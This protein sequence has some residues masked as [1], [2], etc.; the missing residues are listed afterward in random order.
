MATKQPLK[1]TPITTT[2]GGNN[3][4]TMYIIFGIIVI[5]LIFLITWFAYLLWQPQDDSDVSQTNNAVSNSL[6]N[7]STKNKNANKNTNVEITDDTSTTNTNGEDSNSNEGLVEPDDSDNGSDNDNG[8]DNTNTEDENTET[9]YFAAST[10]SCG[11]TIA[12]E[13]ELEL[14]DDPYGEILLS[15]M[16]GPEVDDEGIDGIP[17]TVRLRQVEYTAAGP[18]ITVGEG[19]DTLTNC[20]KQ[21]VDAQF[22]KTANAMFDLPEDTAGEVVVGTI[23]ADDTETEE[24][25]NTNS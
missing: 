22:I 6:S 21:T 15:M 10:S 13:R 3:A 1:P 5:G 24:D 16:A 9:L 4:K 14:S 12:V 25:S 8:N 2:S 18:L 11:D 20:E 19:Y 17:S 7:N 23:E